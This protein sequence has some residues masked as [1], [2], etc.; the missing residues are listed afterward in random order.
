MAWWYEFRMRILGIWRQRFIQ[1]GFCVSYVYIV[2]TL[3]FS[4][5]RS[6]IQQPV[7]D[8]KPCSH[9]HHSRDLEHQGTSPNSPAIKMEYLLIQSQPIRVCTEIAGIKKGLASHPIRPSIYYTSRPF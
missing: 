2:Y 7:S 4:I 8:G 1:R 9:G 3:H 6:E 5:R